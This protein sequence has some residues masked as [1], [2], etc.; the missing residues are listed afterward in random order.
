[1]F[2][3][4]FV[5][6]SERGNFLM[7]SLF[8]PAIGLTAFACGAG[9]ITFGFLVLFQLL[10]GAVTINYH[11]PASWTKQWLVCGVGE[12]LILGFYSIT[13]A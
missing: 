2:L 13:R 11:R 3:K 7:A 6:F 4:W 12:A 10:W 5:P 1:M 9:K 8:L